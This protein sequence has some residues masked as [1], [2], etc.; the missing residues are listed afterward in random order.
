MRYSDLILMGRGA[1]TANGLPTWLGDERWG[2]RKE[3]TS[4]YCA[5]QYAF[6]IYYW[7]QWRMTLELDKVEQGVMT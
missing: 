3:A 5:R 2:W 1:E 7:L 6:S 4:E